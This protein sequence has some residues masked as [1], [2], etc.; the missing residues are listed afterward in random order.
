MR[1]NMNNFFFIES[2]NYFD[3]DEVHTKVIIL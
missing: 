3:Q 1:D 2:D